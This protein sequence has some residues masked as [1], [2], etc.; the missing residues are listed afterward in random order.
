MRQEKQRY[1]LFKI[2]RKD[3]KKNTLNKKSFLN[4]LWNRIWRYF[5]M[6]TAIKIG[7]WLLEFNIEK[8]YGII[9]CSHSTK[10][11]MITSLSLIKEI[12]HERIIISPIKTSGTLEK[13]REILTSNQI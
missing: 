10:E 7:L 9:R 12:N 2:I 11:I 6:K 13:I 5:G 4:V 1:I 8:N 3:E